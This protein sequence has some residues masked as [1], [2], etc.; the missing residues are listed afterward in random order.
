MKDLILKSLRAHQK[1]VIERTEVKNGSVY[2]NEMMED[3]I[4][5]IQALENYSMALVVLEQSFS[6]LRTQPLSLNRELKYKRLAIEHA[7]DVIISLHRR[8][9]GTSVQS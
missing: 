9:G 4:R 7:S 8:F 1:F 5:Y 2:Y 6:Q 3:I